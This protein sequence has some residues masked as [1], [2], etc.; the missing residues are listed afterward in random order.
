M[1]QYNPTS[2]IPHQ[3]LPYHCAHEAK[4]QIASRQLI[5]F[6]GGIAELNLESYYDVASFAFVAVSAAENLLEMRISNWVRKNYQLLLHKLCDITT[7]YS[8]LRKVRL[9][10]I[11][12]SNIGCL[13]QKSPN[14][15]S[16]HVSG[17][18]WNKLQSED[19]A[20]LVLPPYGTKLLNI[21]YIHL[22][23]LNIGDKG[24]KQLSQLLQDLIYLETLSLKDDHISDNG[25]LAIA[26]LKALPHL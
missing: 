14:L 2:T 18:D 15:Q 5:N 7:N 20:A 1:Y 19:A 25:A 22:K 10:R 17:L 11:G 6:T 4:S 8:Q 12:P 16:L 3:P 24:F 9:T 23:G 13:L 26:D 21:R